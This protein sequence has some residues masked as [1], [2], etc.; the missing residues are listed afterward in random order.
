MMAIGILILGV[1]TTSLA[2]GGGMTGMAG[3]DTLQWVGIVLAI[4]L[5]SLGNSISGGTF[6]ALIYDRTPE[7]QRGRAIGIVW[8]FLLIGYAIFG[9]IFG[10]LLPHKDGQGLSF[11]PEALQNVFIIAAVAM[12]ILWLVSMIYEERRARKGGEVY[13]DETQQEYSSS[14]WA[15]LK[16]VIQ[17]RSMRYFMFF[18]ALSMF[19][20]FS[21]DLILEPF[22]GD[23]FKMDAGVTTRFNSY[24]GTTAILGTI[25]FLF[26]SRRYKS[27][28]NRVMSYAGVGFILAA[29]AV[30]TVSAFGQIR[31]LITIGLLL[32]G[33]GLG[34]WNVGTTG[35]M[36]DMS[37]NSR[38]GT[39][40]GFWTLVVTLARGGGQAEG[41][42]LHD[43]GIRVFGTPAA[44]YGI[45][46]LVGTIGLAVSMVMLWQANIKAYKAEQIPMDTATVLAAAL[47]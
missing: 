29:F 23:V 5:F 41:G 34:I 39:F 37:P 46:F 8:T 21:Q 28:N 42:I 12:G 45:C 44:A 31:P 3:K 20:A 1:A 25:L 24:W 13:T 47:D 6:L 14:A 16:L 4:L 43:I 22:G 10:K 40:L 26:L 38:A 36:M 30:F 7:H 15:D 32:L 2:L 19:F 11:A 9:I 27:L 17:N 35:L 18:L 33:A